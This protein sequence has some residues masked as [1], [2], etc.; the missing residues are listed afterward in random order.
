MIKGAPLRWG[1]FG[2]AYSVLSL[3]VTG[4]LSYL[5]NK[6]V[7]SGLRY[8]ST[9]R[10]RRIPLKGDNADSNNLINAPIKFWSK[11][12]TEFRPWRSRRGSEFAITYL[13]SFPFVAIIA[14]PYFVRA[15]TGN[16][17]I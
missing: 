5:M 14:I 1:A 16:S 8:A 4:A 6:L 17:R 7:P 2:S 11:I 9:T 13:S 3:L 15:S 12:R 10:R